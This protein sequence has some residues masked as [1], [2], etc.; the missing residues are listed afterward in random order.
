MS[1]ELKPSSHGTPARKD[2]DMSEIE[3][4]M[5]QCS[6]PDSDGWCVVPTITEIREAADALEAQAARIAE[7]EAACAEKDAEIERLRGMLRDARKALIGD[8][9][10]ILAGKNR[11]ETKRAVER[12]N[13]IT[14][15]IDA[16]LKDQ[17]NG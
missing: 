16:E 11:A 13:A 10:I 5:R 14:E 9:A 6:T 1:E 15:C 12:L 3:L 17:N 7:L 8:T 2:K 4:R